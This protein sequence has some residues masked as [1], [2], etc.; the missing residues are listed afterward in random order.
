[1]PNRAESPDVPRNVMLAGA[2]AV[3]GRP[4]RWNDN[5]RSC[6]P[7]GFEES[8]TGGG[9]NLEVVEPELVGDQ[10]SRNCCE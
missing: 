1:M 10:C 5:E 7:D 4:L 9:R 3:F 6:E 8:R 2:T